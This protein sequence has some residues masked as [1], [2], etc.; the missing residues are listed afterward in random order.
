[1]QQTRIRRFLLL[2]LLTAVAACRST[3]PPG[4]PPSGTIEEGLVTATATVKAV[5]LK[6][7]TVTLTGADGSTLKVRAG[8]QVQNLHQVKAGDQVGVT[9]YE[10]I[11]YAVKRPGDGTPGIVVAEDAER[12]APGAKPGAAG[13]RVVTIT[14]TIVDV[15]RKAGT[16]TIQGPEGGEPMVV[17]V[18]DRSA[19]ERVAKNDLVELT[20]T[21]AVA[22]AVEPPA[23]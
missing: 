17:R 16:V 15:D 2:A 20:V 18:R 3:P 9:Y 13:A 23:H 1:M 6:T 10:S 21:E 4:P 12:A 14:A 8:D 22:V 7:R 11:A 5:D 19:L